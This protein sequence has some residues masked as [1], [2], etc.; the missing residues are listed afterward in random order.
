MF[1]LR[2]AFPFGEF[3]NVPPLD[4]TVT[5]PLP[6]SN[7]TSRS[8]LHQAQLLALRAPYVSS[9]QAKQPTSS[10]TLLST[11]S[12][13]FDIPPQP[14]STASSVSPLSLTF[15]LIWH[16]RLGLRRTVAALK[17]GSTS[18]SAAEG[19]T[20]NGGVQLV[21]RFESE[22]RDGHQCCVRVHSNS[23]GL[24]NGERG[25]RGERRMGRCGVV[26]FLA[27]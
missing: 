15:P 27:E 25:A 24:D 26:C 23:G 8:S 12:S 20:S 1:P 17:H 2:S 14:R 22:Q 9:Q 5:P 11:L 16:P 3:L 6:L 18:G 4:D 21:Q 7:P 19:E 13:P 10:R